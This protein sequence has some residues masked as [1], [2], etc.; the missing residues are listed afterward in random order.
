MEWRGW[1]PQLLGQPAGV[2]VKPLLWVGEARGRLT[3]LFSLAPQE[4]L[5]SPES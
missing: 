5:F 4:G 1:A 2:K 3:P